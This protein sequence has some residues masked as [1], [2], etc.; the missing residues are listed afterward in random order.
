MIIVIA[1]IIV[2]E[3]LFLCVYL[4]VSSAC[5][6]YRFLKIASFHLRGASSPPFDAQLCVII[7]IFEQ[8]GK[9][10]LS[11]SRFYQM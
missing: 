7:R 3:R 1:M 4:L 2:T 5:K 9:L 8:T 6:P 10:Y 11:R